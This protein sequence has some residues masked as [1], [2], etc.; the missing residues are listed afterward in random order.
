MA[1]SPCFA[2]I[3]G[4]AV[5]GKDHVAEVMGENNA[6]EELFCVLECVNSG[7]QGLGGDGTDG[8]EESGV[9][10]MAQEEE[11]TADLLDKFLAILVKWW[12]RG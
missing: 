1:M 7:F 10:H 4:I 5:D 6:I 12:R 2:K 8:A 3:T 9:N 11:F